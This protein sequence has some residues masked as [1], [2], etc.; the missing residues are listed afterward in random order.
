MPNRV[1][2]FVLLL[3][4]CMLTW[5]AD[6]TGSIAGRVVD[7]SN[8]AIAG[9][10]ISATNVNTGLTRETTT[11]VDGGY[12][13]PLLPVGIY[14]IAIEAAGFQRFQQVGIEVQ[15][16]QSSSVPATL[17][18]GSATETVTVQANA[19]MVETQSGALRGVIT[20]QN[21]SELPLNGR[22]AASLILL[23]PG[24]ADLSTG[25]ARGSGDT[26][27]SVTYPGAQSISGNG[28][29]ADTIN[30]NMDGGSN[31]DHY[32]NV[33]NP[34][35]N[36]DAIEEFSVLT[37]SYSAEYGRGSGA[38]VNVVT[39]SGTN[40]LHG[41]LFEFLRNGDM[42]AR[43][44][45]AAQADK[46]KRNQFGVGVGGPM[47]KDKLFFFGSYQGTQIRNV[48][49]GNSATV[50]TA[51]ER[52]GDFSSVQRQLVNPSTG[53][54]FPNNQ[55][56]VSLFTS[57]SQKILQLLPLPN[58]ANGVTYYDLPDREHEN[59]F[60]GRVDYNLSK[61]RIY[62][63]Y[64]DSRYPKDPVVGNKN[65]L[66]SNRG[67][68]LVSQ[69]ASASD[70]Y[71]I[72]PSLL[73]S[74]I[75][76]Y[77]RNDGT[78]VSGAPFSMTDLGSAVT[79]TNPPELALSVSGY[80]SISSGHPTE[81]DRNNFHFSDTIHW[82]K[83]SHDL[84][85]GGDFMRMNV[86]INNTYRQNASFTFK[87]T[88]YSGNALSDFLLGD[89][90]KFIQGG[91]EFAARKGNLGSLFIQDNYR[92]SRALVF[93]LGLRWDPFV[94]YSDAKGRTEC[95]IPG[96]TS[97]RFPN[98]PAGYLFAGDPG[99]PDG[100]FSS[101]WGQFAP[102]LGFAYNVGG[103]GKTTIRGG[104]G[105]F[106]Q[107]PFVEAFNNM[108]DSA[109]FS[110]QYQIFGTSFMN[111]Y[112][113]TT[114]PFPAEYAPQ[115][116]ASNV[117]FALPLSLA[118]A[119]QPNWKPARSMN[120]NLTIERQLANNIVARF[121]Y[122]ASK[123][124]HLSYNTDANA[125]LPS[126][127]ATVD[128]EQA[129]R[130]YQQ[131]EQ[132]TMDMSGGNSIY[133]AL[134]I[135]VEKRFSHGVNV[136]ANYTWS[137]V[138][139]AVSYATDLDT[140]NVINPYN[141]NAFRGVSDYNVPHRFL[142]NY[143]WRLPS[144]K[145]GW[146][147]AVFGGWETT[148][149]WTWQSGFPLNITSGGDYSYSLPESADD[150]AQLV[151]AP[152]YTG[153]ATKDKLNAWFT[154]SAFTTPPSNSFGNVGRNTLIGP[155]TFNID[156][157]VHRTFVIQ[158]RFKLQ[159]RGEAFNALNHAQFNNPDTTVVDSNFGQITGARDPRIMQVALKLVF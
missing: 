34:F 23:S 51:A 24:T 106:Y 40:A 48:S 108:V 116:P 119:Y 25:N 104:W 97:Q 141:V 41:S 145:E 125:P 15:A 89:A 101:S 135:A 11:A 7:P 94:P 4:V 58:A 132:V 55:I 114:N 131:F 84:A 133:N 78:I 47:V 56:P 67:F 100:G 13:L 45:F 42:N 123:G 65:L 134:Q 159:F 50:P 32:T 121:G 129:R 2:F 60:L 130:P 30:Y 36:P 107:P 147:K 49:S 12:V 62:G 140:I 150:Q 120:W 151:S 38:V 54:P 77:N 136:S 66:T 139:D 103:Q 76:S 43:N 59:Q 96:K 111:P 3:T 92:A 109:P 46:L 14:K 61:H 52:A 122:V 142:L 127:M 16:D 17:S 91:G 93:N 149:I 85:M 158:E 64:L 9:A 28:A 88:A 6:P 152:H 126:P 146:T 73:N 115:L 82:I 87:G 74:F 143:L 22:Q 33:N 26:K 19:Q 8:A 112:R 99:C 31:Q 110:P 5:A 156:F 148:G 83:G 128:N 53:L 155:G 1:L 71:T 27:Q 90:Q 118:V 86:N 70:T 63:R 21:I 157:S 153:G 124:T 95:F 35:P 154:T 102:R 113:G 105:M 18:I 10:K 29:R 117:A 57:A 72:S 80:F 81:I 39:K 144:P 75:V 44:F 138:I 137:K 69:S 79:S 68:T 98:A 20:T 37:N